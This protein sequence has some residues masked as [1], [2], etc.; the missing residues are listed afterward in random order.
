MLPKNLSAG[1]E[2]RKAGSLASPRAVH[3]ERIPPTPHTATVPYPDVGDA[4]WFACDQVPAAGTE[5]RTF[6]VAGART[7]N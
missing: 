5:V 1:T 6:T 3:S 4:T 7:A 2:G